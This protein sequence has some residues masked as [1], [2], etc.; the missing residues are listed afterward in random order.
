MGIRTTSLG[1][2]GG[3]DADADA[4][5]SGPVDALTTGAA[6]DSVIDAGADP[7]ATADA[8]AD[9]ATDLSE[10]ALL[11]PSQRAPDKITASSSRMASID[12]TRSAVQNGRGKGIG[13]LLGNGRGGACWGL[14]LVFAPGRQKKPGMHSASGLVGASAGEPFDGMFVSEE[15]MR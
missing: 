13:K 1:A 4:E 8:L 12:T 7:L 2:G 10:H 6:T 9:P 3:A 14:P 15:R 5:A 11:P